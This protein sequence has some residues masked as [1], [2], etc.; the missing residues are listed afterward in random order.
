LANEAALLELEELAFKYY[1]TKNDN[2]AAASIALFMVEHLYY[3]HESH[4][5]AVHQAHSFNKKWGN[6]L[7][8]HPACKGKINAENAKTQDSKL[9]HP[10]SWA[11]NPTATSTP[12]NYS[13]RLEVL[14]NYIY[15]YGDDRMRTRGVLCSVYH[16]ALHDRYYVARDLFLMSHIAD[17]VDRAEVKTQILFNRTLVMLGLCAFRL[18]LFTKAHDCLQVICSGRVK[19][20]LAQGSTRSPD[21]DPEQ[22]RIE[23]R[24]QMPYHM[25]INPDL[26][27]SCHLISAMILEL[28]LLARMNNHN[29]SSSSGV[30][31]SKQLRKYMDNYSRQ[32]FSGP[33]ET[34]REHIVAATKA[35]LK[36]DWKPANEYISSLEVWSLLPA[37]A[38]EKVKELLQNKIREEA[39][40]CYILSNST[41]YDSISLD[42]LSLMF[43]MNYSDIRKMICHM[44]FNKEIA[45]SLE[46][47]GKILIFYKV[48]PTSLQ[49]ACLAAAEK[50]SQLL[51]SNERIVDSLIGGVYGYKDDWNAGK[52]KGEGAGATG[53][54][55]GEGRGGDRDGR[56]GGDRGG[57]GQGQYGLNRRRGFRP[58]SS[59]PMVAKGT[60]MATSRNYQSRGGTGGTGHQGNRNV[61]TNKTHNSG[62]GGGGNNNQ[63]QQQGGGQQRNYNNQNRQNRGNRDG[64]DSD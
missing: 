64:N 54:G 60:R 30:F 8:L 38:G 9:G 49:S 2:K 47:N 12:V 31:I 43:E 58:N 51:E 13:E 39:I 63:N 61:W 33:P 36:G 52:G 59:R 23:R 24:R 20:L 41:N 26:L 34:V 56:G 37:N 15:R 55:R 1:E 45:A 46:Q 14:C 29:G 48:E 11:G 28:P 18:G 25:H 62:G 32:T 40:R 50:L 21:K 16:A 44:I 7:D 5:S 42:L 19:E 17:Y 35:I 57:G 4:A 22:E 10:A 27:E 53:D 6:Y 3:K